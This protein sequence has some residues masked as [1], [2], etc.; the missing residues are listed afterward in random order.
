MA[1]T[2]ARLLIDWNN[3]GL[4]DHPLSDVTRDLI[5]Q[6]K[7]SFRRGR[8]YQS[9]TYGVSVAGRGEF[10]LTD[11]EGKYR[12]LHDS[13]ANLDEARVFPRL[14]VQLQLRGEG[15]WQPGWTGFLDDAT[16][17]ERQGT[18]E[19][20]I[21]ALG[22][23]NF[24]TSEVSLPSGEP[25]LRNRL[26]Q[27]AAAEIVSAV[28]LPAYL[29][30]TFV[31][32]AN[33]QVKEYA[34]NTTKSVQTAPTTLTELRT[35]ATLP[36]NAE[37]DGGA[38]TESGRHFLIQQT[39]LYEVDLAAGTLTPYATG[40]PSGIQFSSLLAVGDTLYFLSSTFNPTT[41]TLYSID[42]TQESPAATSVGVVAT[43]PGFPF[44]INGTDCAAWFQGQ[45]WFHQFGI[46]WF[47]VDLV[48]RT[49]TRVT[50]QTGSHSNYFPRSAFSWFNE[51]L[52]VV[53]N[54][55]DLTEINTTDGEPLRHSRPA[56]LPAVG[57]AGG[58]LVGGERTLQG[59][60]RLPY[61]WA[62]NE[63]ALEAL[64]AVEYS[65][66]GFVYERK[67]GLVGF[68]DRSRRQN[69]SGRLLKAT[70]TDDWENP[71]FED[72]VQ[73][74]RNGLKSVAPTKDVATTIENRTRAFRAAPE[75]ALQVLWELQQPIT[76]GAGST[77]QP[78]TQ[79]IFPEYPTPRAPN[80]SVAASEWTAPEAVTDYDEAPGFSAAIVVNGNSVRLTLT[81]TSAVSVVVNRLQL[82]GKRL[83]EL[84]QVPIV[85]EDADA[86]AS[87]GQRRRL[88]IES[89]WL[90]DL[91]LARTDAE[92]QLSLVSVPREKI[93]ITST[94]AG[95]GVAPLLELD[96]S[97][98]V[99]VERKR[100]SKEFFV[101]SIQYELKQG[102]VVGTYLCSPAAAGG[103]VFILDV[104]ELAG[105]AVLGP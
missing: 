22:P 33:G 10:F 23:L 93:S 7:N 57:A 94:G 45:A 39:T 58:F 18:S 47:T 55:G 99:R 3:D 24:L 51:R 74:D 68:D 29:A 11:H 9:Q 96:L 102:R 70:F 6:K 105:G 89:P 92:F 101:E 12:D 81:N 75:T 17:T 100:E 54:N 79:I 5:Q 85:I 77:A 49:A 16:F 44:P 34:F 32:A 41:A 63:R 20:A 103:R 59:N 91:E 21:K 66:G 28:G 26:T 76:L 31:F 37:F 53:D 104:D 60:T 80:G 13:T 86:I 36:G 8:N 25:I 43:P 15:A 56:Q 2:E 67:D 72:A 88:G 61:W 71:G 98:R 40:I 19:L 62:N 87:L 97:D 46:G 35:I 69:L 52:F 78:F 48:T 38:T 83:E 30:P 73:I 64:R 14:G 95:R 1:T 84:D 65:E 27:E 82:R 90:P 50:S 4:Y 42:T